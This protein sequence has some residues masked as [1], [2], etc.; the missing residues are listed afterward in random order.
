MLSP[1]WLLVSSSQ[2][3]GEASRQWSVLAN[4]LE[5]RADIGFYRGLLKLYGSA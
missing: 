3:N 2:G 5:A 1:L 4:I